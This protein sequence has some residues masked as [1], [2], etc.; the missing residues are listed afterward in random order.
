MDNA[1]QQPPLPPAAGAAPTIGQIKLPPFWPEDPASWF[2]LAEGQFTL[3]NVADPVTRYYHVLAALSVDSVRLVQHVLH[4][5]TGPESYDRLRASLL[6][7]HSLSN[8]QKMERM[9]RLP[10]LGDR[11]PSVIHPPPKVLA[12]HTQIQ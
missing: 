11:K 10:P 3:R 5:D 9:M 12:G 1:E 7:S 4:D 6:A 8:Y 2:R